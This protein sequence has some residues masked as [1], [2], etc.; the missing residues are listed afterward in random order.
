MAQ[1]DSIGDILKKRKIKSCLISGGYNK[2]GE[3]PFKK[4]LKFIKELKRKGIK[5]N[6]HTGLI[7]SEIIQE[8]KEI[9]PVVSFDFL[10]DN[11]TIEEV[12]NSGGFKLS[13]SLFISTFESLLNN[14]IKVIPHIT[15][16][17]FKG[18]IK[19][20]FSALEYL[21]R[22]HI[23]E[24]IFLVLVPTRG[25]DYASLAPPDLYDVERVFSFARRILP[26]TDFSLGCMRPRG[27]Y[28]E[29][30][31]LLAVKYGFGKI[32]MPSRGAEEYVK[33]E[34]FKVNNFYQCCVFH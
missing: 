25:T 12:Y 10:I 21:S 22:K 32:V 27:S 6:L 23:K 20:E 34:G 4:K 33:R 29:K 15:L 7:S 13:G 24:V 5:L 26:D 14:N 2:C 3:V 19:G 28:R 11:E 16:G 8:L 1:I 31:D 18:K 9:D 30:L 17:L